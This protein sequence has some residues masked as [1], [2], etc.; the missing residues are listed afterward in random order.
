M[1]QSLDTLKRKLRQLR[2][3][4]I[5]IRFKDT[6]MPE[7]TRLVWDVFFSTKSKDQDRIK[8][9]LALLLKMTRD[10][11]KSVY[12][13]YF[14]RV[15]YQSYQEHGLK[16]VDVYDSQ[17]LE[18]LGLP[19]YAGQEDIKKRF[20]ELAKRYHPDMGGDSEKFIELM[21]VYRRL[22]DLDG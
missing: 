7:G 19:A 11:L 5:A 1:P 10:K 16:Q 15:Y 8:F 12:E 4:E 20:R 21:N 22:T 6:P 13:E 18:L 9:P 17:L 2:Q 3:L 14:Y